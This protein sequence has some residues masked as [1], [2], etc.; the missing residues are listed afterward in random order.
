MTIG[1]LTRDVD[2]L[3]AAAQQGDSAA[4]AQLLAMHLPY[5]MAAARQIIA[6]H[7]RGRKSEKVLEEPADLVQEATLKL[8]EL[9]KLGK[10][11]TSNTRAYVTTM[12]RNSYSNSLRSTRAKE[13]PLEH[14]DEEELPIPVLDDLSAVDLEKELALI[15]GALAHLSQDHREVLLAVIVEGRKPGELV[16][17]LRRPAPAISNLLSRAKQALQRQM[18]LEHLSDGGSE[19]TQNAEH[20][21]P[22]VHLN[23]SE[24]RDTG[25]GIPHV[26]HC[27]YCQRNWRR[28]ALFASAFGVLPLLQIA[29]LSV[30]PA[31]VAAAATT[32]GDAS[33]MPQGAGGGGEALSAST[34]HAGAAAASAA[35]R[36]GALAL[37]SSTRTLVIGIALSCAAAILVPIALLAGSN[38]SGTRSDQPQADQAQTS[39]QAPENAAFDVDLSTSADRQSAEITA[40][41]TVADKPWTMSETVLHLSQGTT[42]ESASSNLTCA[43]EG[44]TVRC[45]PAR[46]F[47]SSERF[48]LV[49]RNPQGSGRFDL[50]MLGTIGGAPYR[51]T[52]IG[53]W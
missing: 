53:N 16:D 5:W 1:D 49:V 23:V 44:D 30:G 52:A 32:V 24:H 48:F 19:C 7:G 36:S 50:E 29:W 35:V 41:F 37:L 10:G 13:Q 11:P 8:V 14:F 51:G 9:W 6:D 40:V 43:A 42:F 18:L 33:G 21:P 12:M 25:R 22:R 46:T 26:R 2:A 20:L 38:S 47:S 45:I 31:P 34:A 15:R 17:Q 27:Q 28:F 39:V 4:A 3:T